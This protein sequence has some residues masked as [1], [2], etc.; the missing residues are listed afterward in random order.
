MPARLRP[1][2][3]AGLVPAMAV[4]LACTGGLAGCGNSSSNSGTVT[5]STTTASAS[6]VPGTVGGGSAS[7]TPSSVADGIGAWP[8]FLPSPSANSM[9]T[10]TLADPVMSYPG[11]PVQVVLSTGRVEMLVAGPK[12]PDSTKV[13]ADKVPC[14]FTITFSH[15]TPTS[16][17]AVSLAG[18]RFDVLDSEGGIHQLKLASGSHLP[19]SVA[20]GATA[21][22]QVGATLPSGEGLLRYY[23]VPK[24]GAI[25][26]WDYV[27]ETD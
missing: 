27:A 2:R 13:G 20:P 5:S 19:V 21:T 12:Y 6:G 22:V 10:G 7:G 26:A 17:T 23:P 14:T 11:N 1:I 15:A 24:Q 4:A 16:G 3:T 25:G 9:P 18:A 8:S